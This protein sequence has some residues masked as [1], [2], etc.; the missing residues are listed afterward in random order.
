MSQENVVIVRQ[1]YEAWMAGDD[2]A[3]YSI[4]DPAIRLNPDPEASWVGMD[5]EYI[6]HDG[7]RRY[8]LAVYEAFEDYR[9]EVEQIIDAGEGRVLTL[10]VEHGRGRGSGAEVQAAKTAHLWTMQN[11]KAVRLDLFLD[12]KSALEAVGLSEQDAHAD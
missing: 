10:A 12:R 4:F 9:P 6:G 2:E 5:E 11:G 3:I 7:M 8:M 1:M